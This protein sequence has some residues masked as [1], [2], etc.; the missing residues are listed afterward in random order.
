[1]G[2]R[3]TSS[4][5]VQ[6][7]RQPDVSETAREQHLLQDTFAFGFLGR[8]LLGH[9][10]CKQSWDLFRGRQDSHPSQVLGKFTFDEWLAH[11]ET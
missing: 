7:G 4:A 1:M 11:I 5:A 6:Q 3:V 2:H 10:A 8:L 9:S